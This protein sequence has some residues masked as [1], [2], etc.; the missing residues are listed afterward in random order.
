MVSREFAKEGRSGV[1]ASGGRFDESV[2]K[3]IL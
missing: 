3:I 2:A 1:C